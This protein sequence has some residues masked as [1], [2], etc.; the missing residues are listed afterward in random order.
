MSHINKGDV[1]AYL[2]GAL[3]A[4]PEE[5]ARHVREHLDACRECAQLLESE[6]RLRQ[7][8]SAILAVFGTGTGGPRLTRG[9]AGQGC[10]GGRPGAG[11]KGRGV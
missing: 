3:D 7:E 6:R 4:Y 5:A 1:H 10:G 2:D 8:A 11:R 9:T